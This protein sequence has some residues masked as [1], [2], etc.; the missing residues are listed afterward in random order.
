[1]TT[2]TRSSDEL[3]HCGSKSRNWSTTYSSL[4]GCVHRENSRT[5]QRGSKP[6]SER[7]P[8][9]RLTPDRMINFMVASHR[10]RL[11]LG[12]TGGLGLLLP[13]P[14]RRWWD[15]S[16]R[17]FALRDWPTGVGSAAHPEAG[18]GGVD[19]VGDAPA[20]P[21]RFGAGFA[22]GGEFVQVGHSR[23]DASGLGDRDPVQ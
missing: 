6:T 1:V 17:R 16:E 5:M 19:G 7:K 13:P 10:D 22:T 21:D 2:R 3:R 20:Q 18:E 8:S 15:A 23:S 4:R 9:A 14:V 11:V 12:M